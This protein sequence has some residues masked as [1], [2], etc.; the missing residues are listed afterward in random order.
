M[1]ADGKGGSE[2]S[3]NTSGCCAV[4]GELAAVDAD[5]AGD[6]RVVAKE[7]GLAAAVTGVALGTGENAQPGPGIDYFGDSEEVVRIGLDEVVAF[8]VGGGDVCGVAEIYA[9]RGA[10]EDVVLPRHGEDGAVIVRGFNVVDA[11]LEGAFEFEV[12]T[13]DEV[14]GVLVE[15]G[16]EPAADVFDPGAGSIDKGRN[17]HFV[18]GAIG[19]VAHQVATFGASRRKELCGVAQGAAEGFG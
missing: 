10:E 16:G 11:A 17:A 12:G 2:D 19:A 4:A 9:L 18:V 5:V 3:Q 1:G 7:E 13:G 8:V 14:N 15:G 6:V